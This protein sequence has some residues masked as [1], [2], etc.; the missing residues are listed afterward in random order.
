MTKTEFSRFPFSHISQSKDQRTFSPMPPLSTDKMSSQM[1]NKTLLS[2]VKD[3]ESRNPSDNP[4]LT[5]RNW[6]AIQSL[7]K[8]SRDA[9]V[10]PPGLQSGC[11]MTW[12]MGS[13]LVLPLW[14]L[15]S[16]S[17]SFQP[18]S[19]LSSGGWATQPW[20]STREVQ[21]GPEPPPSGMPSTSTTAWY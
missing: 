1:H 12:S 9:A 13:D 18:Y 16:L 8:V 10:G 5:T 4:F 11:S 2:F 19:T 3:W 15:Q 7:H 14:Q 17:G 6:Q 21:H 20:G